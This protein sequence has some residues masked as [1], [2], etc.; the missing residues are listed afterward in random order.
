MRYHLSTFFLL[1]VIVALSLGWYREHNAQRRMW[2]DLAGVWR[3]T[4][5]NQY[6]SDRYSELTIRDGGTFSYLKVVRESTHYFE[7]TY[8]LLQ[9]G[10]VRLHIHTS[11]WQSH[12]FDDTDGPSKQELDMAFLIEYHL[13]PQE[14]LCLDKINHL[15]SSNL[16]KQDRLLRWDHFY[17]RK[18]FTS[19]EDE[20][21]PWSSENDLLGI[22]K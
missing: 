3:S 8:E 19:L 9:P 22:P 6:I 4:L 10:K 15:P 16:L 1:M 17:S 2:P 11:K 21:E 13:S 14:R 18:E 20:L 12:L 7:G 5:P